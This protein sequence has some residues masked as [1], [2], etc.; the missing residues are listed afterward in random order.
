MILDV[1]WFDVV[2]VIVVV[3]K[4]EVAGEEEVP[5]GLEGGKEDCKKDWFHNRGGS[6]MLTE[7]NNM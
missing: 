3:E 6:L 7:R 5:V 4:E 1:E 2:D